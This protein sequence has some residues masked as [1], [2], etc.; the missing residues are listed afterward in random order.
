MGTHSSTML[1]ETSILLLFIPGLLAA[2]STNSLNT[3]DIITRSDDDT[4]VEPVDFTTLSG[5]SQ[6]DCPDHDVTVD[7]LQIDSRFDTIRQIR[8]NNCG[9]CVKF[10]TSKDGCVDFDLCSKKHSICM[11]RGKSRMHWIE[12]GKKWCYK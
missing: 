2:P 9:R 8:V 10:K 12:N 1:F 3:G 4:S 7:F 5:C 11:D 6:G